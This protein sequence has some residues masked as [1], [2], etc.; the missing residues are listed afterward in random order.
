MDILGLDVTWAPEFAEAGWIRSGPA[1]KAAGRARHAEAACSRRP[2]GT[3]SS[4]RRRS[5]RNTQL[6]WYR[7][8][9]V[10]TRPRRGTQMIEMAERAGQAGQAALHRDPGQ[11]V[12]GHHRVV[13]HAACSRRRPDPE[14][15]RHRR[16]L[17]PPAVKALNVMHTLAHSPAADPSLSGQME[18]HNRLAMEAGTAAFELNYPFVY[19]SMQGQQARDV[20]E[21]QVGALPGGEARRAGA[22]DH[23]RHQPGGQRVLEAPRPGLRGD[24]VPAEPARTEIGATSG[25]LPPVDRVDLL[26]RAGVPEGAT[27]SA[28]R[29]STRCKTASVR[30]LTPA[31]QN[32]SILIS[33]TLSPPTAIEPER[34][35]RRWRASIKDALDSKGLVP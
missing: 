14:R 6:L 30:P 3:A 29:S 27:R 9:L 7:S 21:L 33:H 32:I 10:P 19:P 15:Q 35:R 18:D 5:T 16:S 17:G 20:Q 24:R 4:R 11:P 34:A 2:P 22:R 28:R 31:Y 23:R 1:N 25:G 26:R 12:R 13:Q 8:D